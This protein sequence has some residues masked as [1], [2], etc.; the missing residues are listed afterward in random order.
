[1]VLLN[2]TSFSGVSSQSINNVFS[3][4]YQNYRI[5]VSGNNVT[6][7]NVLRLRLRASG[8]DNTSSNYIYSVFYV[9]STG[10]SGVIASSTGNTYFQLGEFYRRTSLVTI[11]ITNPFA[12]DYTTYNVLNYG[13]D[14][15]TTQYSTNGG[16]NTTV[17]TSYDGFT[18]FP[19]ANTITGTVRVYGYNQ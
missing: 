4:T 12:T 5:V 11:D 18:I 1:M 15:S 16:G 10:A 8:T 14:S 3:A 13:G 7:T 17:T 9:A 19:D 6:G 2:T